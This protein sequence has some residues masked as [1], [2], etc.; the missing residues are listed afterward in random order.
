M[1]KELINSISTLIENLNKS[2]TD[3]II[4][5]TGNTLVIKVK[6]SDQYRYE[7][8]KERGLKR[9]EKLWDLSETSE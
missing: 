6:T 2:R 8:K 4:K 1:R 5:K 3:F 7:R 9:W